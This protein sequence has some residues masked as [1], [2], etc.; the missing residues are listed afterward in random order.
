MGRRV[1]SRCCCANCNPLGSDAFGRADS[2]S[3]GGDWTEVAGDFE[4]VSNK[5]QTNDSNALALFGTTL[6]AKHHVSAALQGNAD[7]DVLRLFADY[8]DSDNYHFGEFTF[9]NTKNSRSLKV[10]KRV[11]GVETIYQTVTG[12]QWTDANALDTG[13]ET[14]C[15]ICLRPTSCLAYAWHNFDLATTSVDAAIA[16]MFTTPIGGLL[17]G[18]A[19]GAIAGDVTFD[20]FNIL[21]QLDISAGTPNQN[22]GCRLVCDDCEELT[23]GREWQI[24]IAG[25]ANGTGFF[26]ACTDATNLNA[27]WLVPSKTGGGCRTNSFTGGNI[28]GAGNGALAMGVNICGTAGYMDVGTASNG[29]GGIF[30]DVGIA[31]SGTVRAVLRAEITHRRCSDINHTL[32]AIFPTG[33]TEIDFSAATMSVEALA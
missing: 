8:V 25:V 27:T 7:G 16:G 26:G 30:V 3:L 11:A 28:P 32:T 33:T 29:A 5:L 1:A 6:P 19:T 20:D 14:V 12:A 18:A 13:A 9:H 21:E 2:T 22:C 15:S 17:G 24:T 31:S 23:L 4:I 10:G